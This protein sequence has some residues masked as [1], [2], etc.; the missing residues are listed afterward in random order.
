MSYPIIN[1]AG[2]KY[3][4]FALCAITGKRARQLIDGDDKLTNCSS[5]KAIT[6]AVDEINEN[7][8]ICKIRK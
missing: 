6:V 5:K 8:I 7:K 3:S 2:K 4:R 1:P